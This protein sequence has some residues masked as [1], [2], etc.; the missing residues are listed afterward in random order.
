MFKSHWIK[1]LALTVV[2][3]V[4]FLAL[5]GKSGA[6]P[7]RTL[8]AG[9]ICYSLGHQRLQCDAGAS[10]GTGSYS[11][12]WSPTPIAGGHEEGLAIVRC[13]RAYAYQT[14]SVTV[15]DNGTSATANDSGSF[16]CGD[17]Q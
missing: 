15:T 6:A 1:V 16:F 7:R 14:V 5:S 13:A 11:Y 8:T 4:G 9:L 17:A 12:Q 2:V 10:G 3:A